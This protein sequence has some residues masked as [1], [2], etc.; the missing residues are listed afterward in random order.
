VDRIGDTYRWKS[1]NVST[2]EVSEALS[3]FEGAEL[4]NIYGVKVPGHEGR[5]GMAAIVMQAGHRF[6]PDCFYELTE[7]RLPRYAAPLFVRIPEA[8]DLT[9]TFKLRKVDL[10]AQGYD[11]QA[12]ADPLYV[13]DDQLGTYRPY[14]PELLA[15][16]GLP[17]FSGA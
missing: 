15:E 5:A 17:P 8:A 14:S 7:A 1:E 13:R 6:D 12:F 3:D 4:I 10:Q 9:T 16:L 11:D 2:L